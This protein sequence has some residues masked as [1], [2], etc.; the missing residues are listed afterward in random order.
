HEIPVEIWQNH[1][2]HYNAWLPY[3][4]TLTWFISPSKKQDLY[5]ARSSYSAASNFVFFDGQNMENE[6]ERQAFHAW[7]NERKKEYVRIRDY[8]SEDFYP[9][10][11]SSDRKDIWCAAQFH[12]PEQGDGVVQIFRRENA[13]YET[14][15]FTL[16]GIK[17][18]TMYAFTDVDGGEFTVSG[19]EINAHGWMVSMPEKRSA[20]I[21]FYREIEG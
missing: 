17:D 7:Q 19:T 15:T 21:Y 5:L 16:R 9:L 12:R 10:T 4:G 20:K 8:F 18:G 6:E 2:L 3:S 1:H 13:P 11:E 14:A